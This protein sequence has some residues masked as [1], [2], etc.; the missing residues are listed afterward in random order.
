MYFYVFYCCV[1]VRAGCLLVLCTLVIFRQCLSLNLILAV[2]D[3]WLASS[4]DPPVFATIHNPQC[5]SYSHMWLCSDFIWE[6]W[7]QIILLPQQAPIPTEPPISKA[8]Y[9]SF[10]FWNSCLPTG[11]FEI[12]LSRP[13]EQQ[14]NHTWFL[15]GW[16][17]NPGLQAEWAHALPTELPW[18]YTFFRPR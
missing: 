11:D 15:Q 18:A 16:T 13:L 6:I 5:W 12:P 1:S 10:G 9:F 4:Q 17:L 14:G 8:S 2:E 3:W 7:T